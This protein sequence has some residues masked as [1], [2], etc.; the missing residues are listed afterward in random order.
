ML[1]EGGC[2]GIDSV[3]DDEAAAGPPNGIECYGKRIREQSSSEALTMERFSQS[4]SGEK[5]GRNVNR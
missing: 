5:D 3:N 2:S 1:V 4:K